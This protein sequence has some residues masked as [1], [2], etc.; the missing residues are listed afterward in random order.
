MI[1]FLIVLFIIPENKWT[2]LLKTDFD[3]HK[4][5]AAE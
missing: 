5:K 2:L 3:K 4:P 1:S